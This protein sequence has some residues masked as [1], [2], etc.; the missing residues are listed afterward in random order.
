MCSVRPYG[1][2]RTTREQNRSVQSCIIEHV[3]ED[4]EPTQT[5]GAR[6]VHLGKN[7]FDANDMQGC[8]DKPRQHT[9]YP[10]RVCQVVLPRTILHPTSCVRMHAQTGNRIF[11][12]SDICY[13]GQ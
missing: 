7:R 4:F 11:T 10:E 9:L 13:A 3:A 1:T 6:G 5:L 2:K 8:K 12:Q